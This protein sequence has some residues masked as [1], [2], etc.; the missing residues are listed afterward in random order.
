[1]HTFNS[2][3]DLLQTHWESDLPDTVLDALRP[4]DGKPVT[5]R[6]LN[7]L[8]GGKDEWRLRRE[9]GMTH[10]ENNAY[11]RSSGNTG[12]SLLLDWRTDAFLLN[13]ANVE[14][15]NTAYFSARKSRNHSRM[16]ARN[17][18][19]LLDQMAATLN[20]VETAQKQLAAAKAQ[21]EKLTDYGAPFAADKYEL[22]RV[23]GLR[24]KD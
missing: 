10:L 13:I 11:W 8:P 2:V 19:Q 20:A 14:K 18:K 24:T 9:Y 17:D 4:F 7:K 21:F 12:I 6:L 15:N 23:C 5:T 16:E 22:E 3:A 1:M